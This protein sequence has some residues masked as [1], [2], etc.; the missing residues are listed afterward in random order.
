[1]KLKTEKGVGGRD[2][3]KG[4]AS[5]SIHKFDDELIHS[6]PVLSEQPRAMILKWNFAVFA[7]R[8]ASLVILITFLIATLAFSVE[9]LDIRE[10]F[11]DNGMKVLI[12]E[13]HSAPLVAVQ[14]WVGVGAR[15]EPRGISGVSH[16]IEHMMFKGT[17][18]MEPAEFSETIQR[19]GGTENAGTSRDF[20]NY[21]AYVPS[22][23]VEEAMRLWAD[24][25]RG[26]AF[27][28]DEFL[29]ERDVVQEELRLGLNDPQD[30][31]FEA[32]TAASYQA[33]PYGK[34]VVG[35]ISDLQ[36][37]TRDEAYNY[38]K[39]YYVPDNMKLI[40]TGDVTETS[41]MR[42]ARKHFGKM[43]RGSEP[44]KMPTVEPKQTGERR[45]EVRRE[46][47][48]PMVT[49]TWHIPVT[50]DPDMLPL[51]VLGQILGGGESSRLHRELVYERQIC[52]SVSVWPYTLLDPGLFYITCMVSRG[53]TAEEAEKGVYEALEKLKAEPV[54]DRELKKAAN[55]YLSNFVF[56]QESILVQA[57]VIGYYDG[58][59]SYEVVNQLPEMVRSVTKE[60]IMDVA[61]RYLTAENR[62]VATLVPLRPK[63]SGMPMRSKG[64]HM[65]GGMGR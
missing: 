63:E 38:Y 1:M 64:G 2:L 44:P 27:K 20:T 57:F 17:S 62:T 9:K 56:R 15:N 61:N 50:K 31:V 40:I 10:H 54:E 59:I 19:F 55:K 41:A 43:E 21:F 24:I 16:L 32:A 28:P 49:M 53:H 46:A 12:L 6:G 26:A 52:T 47:F 29:S 37:I 14:V 22:S 5:P 34:P 4:A 18:R 51:E 23:R 36:Q 7:I 33:H 13:D 11:L 45:V 35:W 39:T 30:A 65:P 3:R 25:M 58:L 60:Q 8:S 48:L 42:L